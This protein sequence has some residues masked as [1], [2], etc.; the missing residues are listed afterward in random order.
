[1]QTHGILNPRAGATRFDLQRYPPSEDLAPLVDRYW[2]V[3][4]DLRGDEP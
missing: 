4:W 2:A 1:M 3:R